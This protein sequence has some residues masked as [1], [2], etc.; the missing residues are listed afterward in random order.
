MLT[1]FVLGVKGDG[2]SGDCVLAE[3]VVGVAC[4]MHPRELGGRL[5]AQ[6]RNRVF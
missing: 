4:G 6:Q 2:G 1:C 3:V 5:A